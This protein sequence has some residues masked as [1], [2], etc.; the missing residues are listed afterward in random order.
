MYEW[1][2]CTLFLLYFQKPIGTPFFGNH[3]FSRQYIRV[4]ISE[5]KINLKTPTKNIF[6]HFLG[7]LVGYV[8]RWNFLWL[9][10]LSSN[11]APECTHSKSGVNEPLS[12]EDL[13]LAYA[14]IQ[15]TLQQIYHI[16]W[17]AYFFLPR[18]FYMS[19]FW[20]QI[21]NYLKRQC[22]WMN[23]FGSDLVKIGMMTDFLMK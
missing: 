2:K 23:H 1:Y 7:I 21:F 13:N 19:C 18:W 8:I 3:S 20:I 10:G 22:C 9:L 16:G 4:I 6:L 11:I 5:M 17:S 12:W 15:V 14:K